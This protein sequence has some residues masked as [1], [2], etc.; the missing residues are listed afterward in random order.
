MNRATA[1][2]LVF[3]IM[4]SLACRGVIVPEC[5]D[6]HVGKLAPATS[7]GEDS[8]CDHCEH[9]HGNPLG[10]SHHPVSDSELRSGAER[11]PQVQDTGIAVL[12]YVREFAGFSPLTSP[13]ASSGA[14]DAQAWSCGVLRC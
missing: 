12:P 5:R 9:I 4:L 14:C 3:L 8:D 10:C 11:A 1:A 2:V 6:C 13:R 7:P